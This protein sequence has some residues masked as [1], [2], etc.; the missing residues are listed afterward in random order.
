MALTYGRDHSDHLGCVSIYDWTLLAAPICN[1]EAHQALTDNEFGAAEL[2]QLT[3]GYRKKKKVPGVDLFFQASGGNLLYLVIRHM[4]I[5]S[6][7]RDVSVLKNGR[8]G[9]SPYSS[10][11]LRHKQLR[12]KAQMVH[13]PTEGKFLYLT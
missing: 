12:S 9:D 4:S 3:R 2:V 5:Y 10:T 13:H 8:E 7:S 6:N 11:I 1:F